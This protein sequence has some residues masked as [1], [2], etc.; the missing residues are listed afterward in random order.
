[1]VNRRIEMK[2]SI[3]VLIGMVS[4][5]LTGCAGTTVIAAEPSLEPMDEVT[6]V[7]GTEIEQILPDS[8][9]SAGEPTDAF[10]PISSPTYTEDI[11]PI[12]AQ[13]CS[14]C[15]GP[16]RTA[17][18]NL[19]T[20]EGIMQGS[21]YG[22]AIEPGSAEDSELVQRQRRG[23]YRQLNEEDLALI[24]TWIDAGAPE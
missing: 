2:Q 19:T 15:H 6:P 5:V 14:A 13:E 18:L 1:M 12:F 24:I 20:Y 22:P 9:E 21:Y 11:Q 23:H 8:T 10:D 3:I 4:F 7:A 16:G 17:G